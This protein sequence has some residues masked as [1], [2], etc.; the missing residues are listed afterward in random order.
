MPVGR[1]THSSDVVIRDPSGV[2]HALSEGTDWF[3]Q[4]H[5]PGLYT[6]VLDGSEEGF[7][8]NLAADESRTAGL[9]PDELARRGVSL[10]AGAAP[11]LDPSSTRQQQDGELEGGQKL[12]RWLVIL[13]V[14]ALLFETLWAG[15]LAR[16]P[17]PSS[18][19]EAVPTVK[20]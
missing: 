16:R 1:W 19:A 18:A 8:V 20:A 12:W 15:V 3:S 6:V 17:P 9:D 2:E 4:T 7:A 5:E 10:L 14:A 11:T 13:A